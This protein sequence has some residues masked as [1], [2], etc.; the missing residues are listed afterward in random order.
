MYYIQRWRYFVSLILALCQ[1]PKGSGC[2]ITI[3][4]SRDYKWVCQR[5][6]FSCVECAVKCEED[7]RCCSGRCTSKNCCDTDGGNCDGYEKDISATTRKFVPII[8]SQSITFKR[9]WNTNN[10]E[11]ALNKR[12]YLL[13]EKKKKNLRQKYL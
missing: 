6:D 8:S 11:L 3:R 9:S 7:D 5:I 2:I 10:H 4:A 13:N 1:K 12:R